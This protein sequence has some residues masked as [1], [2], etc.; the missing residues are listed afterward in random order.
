MQKM[1][2]R[3]IDLHMHSIVS[4]GTD[5]PSELLEHIRN[6]GITLFSLTDHDAVNG[7]AMIREILREND[8]KLLNG[9]EFSCRDE[10]GKYHILGYNYDPDSKSI[11]DVVEAGHRYQMK[12][13]RTRLDY[14][15]DEYGFTFSEQDTQDLLAMS[16]PGKPHIANLM[17]RYGYAPSKETAICDYLNKAPVH[18]EYVRPEDA[19]QSI[20]AGNGIPVL[21]HPAYGSGDELIVGSEMDQRLRRLIEYGLQGVEAFYS[22]FPPK[23]REETL[24]FAEKY[25]LYVTAGSDYHGKNKFI[26]L[27]K[28]NLDKAAEIPGGMKR[29]LAAVEYS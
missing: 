28:T 15:R 1:E 7:C 29:F 8:P 10:Q 20:L 6:A 22:A 26:P 21:A 18:S 24:S 19:I 12:K 27:G 14:I 13:V 17:V 16:S 9:T 23:L 4:D 11:K 5:T 3:K 25:D 2:I